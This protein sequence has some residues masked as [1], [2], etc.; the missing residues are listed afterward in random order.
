MDDNAKTTETSFE[1][2]V[3]ARSGINTDDFNTI[4]IRINA[5]NFV[6]PFE[7]FVQLL[8]VLVGNA[9]QF[10]EARVSHKPKA[11]N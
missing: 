11:P 1:R 9:T 8:N 4:R 10:Q 2:L 5:H 7:E 3:V 6:L